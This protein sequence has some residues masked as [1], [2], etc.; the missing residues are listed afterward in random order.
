MKSSVLYITSQLFSETFIENLV[1]IVSL[2]AE[3]GFLNNPS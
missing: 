3:V 1:F 2:N